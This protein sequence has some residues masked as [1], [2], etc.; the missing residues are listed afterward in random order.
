MES[1]EIR[2]R[3]LLALASGYKRNA[4]FCQK[5]GMNPTYFS[6]LKT[7]RKTV[8]DE[9]ARRIEVTMGL[10]R[11]YLDTQKTEP[12][13]TTSQIPVE[14]LGIAYALESLSPATREALSRLIYTLAAEATEHKTRREQVVAPFSITIG[15]KIDETGDPVRKEAA[16]G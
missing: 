4:E 7:R 14:T 5:I 9:L 11:G 15:E 10:P 6:Q 8:G 13:A 16:T 3:N 2:L 12:P 1:K